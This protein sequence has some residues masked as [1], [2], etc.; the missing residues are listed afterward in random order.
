MVAAAH[1]GHI[2]CQRILQEQALHILTRHH[3]L[4]RH[5]VG[6]VKNII[7]HAALNMVNLAMA[8]ACADQRADFI[9]ALRRIFLAQIAIAQIMYRQRESAEKALQLF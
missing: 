2:L 1:H 8:L 5:T 7:N 4:T 6:K 3:N 9:L